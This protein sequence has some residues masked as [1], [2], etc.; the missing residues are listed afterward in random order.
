[1]ATAGLDIVVATFDGRLV[2]L[3]GA[4]R[5]VLWQRTFDNA[6]TYS[7][8][9]L[10]FFDADDVPDVFAVF[11]HG[12]FPD[13]TSAERVLLSGRD[14]SVL[15][16]GE[17]GDFATAGDVAVDL[18]GDGIDEVMFNANTLNDAS[19]ARASRQQVHL[20]DSAH[21]EARPWGMPLGDFAIGSPWVGELDDDGRLDLVLPRHSAT[22]GTN[23]G[24]LTRFKVAAPVPARIRWGGYFGNAVRLRGVAMR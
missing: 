2:V 17:T 11:L 18:D 1:M 24:L 4:T 8:P 9:T 21:R 14:G 15:W 12:V 6:E 3:S 13:Y 20:L 10:G 19:V 5:A 7:T 16:R 23:D 22:E